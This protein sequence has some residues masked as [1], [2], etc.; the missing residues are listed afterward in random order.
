MLRGAKLIY[1]TSRRPPP[2]DLLPGIKLCDLSSGSKQPHNVTL[3]LPEKRRD[4]KSGSA[5]PDVEFCRR[6]KALLPLIFLPINT[7]EHSV[8]SSPHFHFLFTA[9]DIFAV[10]CGRVMTSPAVIK[11][12]SCR[13]TQEF[14]KGDDR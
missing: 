13:E 9:P 8:K 4:S 7:K 1:L 2:G 6:I 11:N 3:D 10:Q 5:R 14:L 12:R